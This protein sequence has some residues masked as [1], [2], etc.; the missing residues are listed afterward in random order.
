MTIDDVLITYITTFNK[1]HNYQQVSKLQV[2]CSK[3]HYIVPNEI[4]VRLSKIF[5][6]WKSAS[7]GVSVSKRQRLSK[8]V[9]DRQRLSKTVK[10]WQRL[11]K[12]V[13]DRQ[14]PSKT[15]K[16]CQRLSVNV[17]DCQRL[18]VNVKRLSKTEG[19]PK[20]RWGNPLLYW[21]RKKMCGFSFVIS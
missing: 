15:V 3:Y 16:D 1:F 9:K 6:Y 14:R 5:Y 4:A 2:I 13:K 10:D 21:L 19:K 18:S 20:L 12:T 17:K 7:L 8:T 11:S